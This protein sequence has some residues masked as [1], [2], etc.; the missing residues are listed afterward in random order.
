MAIPGA[1]NSRVI[2]NTKTMFNS[3][4]VPRF[5]L[6]EWDLCN[7]LLLSNLLDAAPKCE[8]TYTVGPL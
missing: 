6:F 8:G 1:K 2:M 7:S 5:V 3:K 4:Y